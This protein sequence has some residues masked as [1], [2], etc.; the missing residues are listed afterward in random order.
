MGSLKGIVRKS[1]ILSLSIRR[2]F[3]ILLPFIPAGIRKRLT[4]NPFNMG[5]NDSNDALEQERALLREV[6]QQGAGA[7]LKTY[8]KLCGPGW[9]QGAITLGGGSLVGALG[10]G[11]IG[12]MH[13]M[14]VQPL[15]MILGVIMLSAIAYVTL[16]T[17]VR[18]FK[19]I[20][21]HVSPLLGW[22][23]L[24]AA[25]VANMVWVLPQFSLAYGAVTKNLQLME[26]STGSKFLIS[27]VVL[28]VATCVIWAYGSGSKGVKLFETVLKIMV[29][30][31]VLS[32]VGVVAVLTFAEDSPLD[33]GAVFAGLIPD[34]SALLRPADSY[35][36]FLSQLDP[37]RAEEWSRTI[38]DLQR[39]R[40]MAAFATAVGI[41][42][43]F[44]LPYSMLKR[45][46]GGEHRGLAIFDL[47]TGLFI[48]F[49]IA[50]GCLVIAAASQF[51]V[52]QEHV[53]YG[54][55]DTLKAALAAEVGDG[56]AALEGEALAAR[57][58]SVYEGLDG[59]TKTEA[60]LELITADRKQ[61][62]LAAALQPFTGRFF[63]QTIFG[64]GVLAMAISTIIILMLING[65]A[66]CEM[67]GVPDS[68]WPHRIGCFIVG[69]IGFFGPIAWGKLGPWLAIPVSV[70]GLMLLPI[71]YG[72]FLLLMNSKS[73]LGDARPEGARRLGWNVLMAIATTIATLGAAWAAHSKIAETVA[74]T[75]GGWA[76]HSNAIGWLGPGLIAIF[77]LAVLATHKGR[78]L[79]S[80]A[81]ALSEKA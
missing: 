14:W 63:S 51:H 67:L 59:A 17:G 8:G 57:L 56:T 16:S 11:V 55:S 25:M 1:L 34:F 26:D 75:K 43:T 64:L 9:L 61:E 39:D 77:A 53:D 79:G 24:L 32:F 62:D 27:G 70:F 18:P 15:A 4:T 12:G 22:G 71:A 42:M 5:D 33:W 10:V 47:S 19:G 50:T 7:K 66:F 48:P 35:Q 38:T 52:N 72:T 81:A 76:A 69:V 20:N 68:G 46:W 23:W 36:P 3:R 30:F 21:E 2:E 58:Q 44:L 60:T 74:K 73:L 80:S 28:A 78:S 54:T 37:A 49:F 31:I 45:G 6:S 41:N 65:F 29:A 13:F 40:I